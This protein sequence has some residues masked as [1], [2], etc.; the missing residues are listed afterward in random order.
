[1]S[2]RRASA[3]LR[4]YAGYEKTS[5]QKA[6]RPAVA[7][8][9]DEDGTSSFKIRRTQVDVMKLSSALLLPAAAVAF[10]GQAPAQKANVA[11]GAV[12]ERPAA[13]ASPVLGFHVDGHA[14][15]VNSAAKLDEEQWHEHDGVLHK[16][17]AAGDHAHAGNW[18]EHDGVWHS[19]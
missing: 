2:G 7:A 17:A 11:R 8:T 9:S 10:V 15:V 1:M 12:L 18:H 16:H 5:T 6:E 4:R 19:H 14:V 13:A 3:P